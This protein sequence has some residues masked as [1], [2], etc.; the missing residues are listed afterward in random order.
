MRKARL[1]PQYADLYPDV[2]PGKWVRAS[3][4]AHTIQRRL[5]AEQGL[6]PDPTRRILPD[7]HFSFSG[8][9][10]RRQHFQN[11]RWTDVP[12]HG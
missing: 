7:E 12:G 4:L 8:G 11:T 10:R 3:V 2:Y 1:D 9:W 6:D 5:D